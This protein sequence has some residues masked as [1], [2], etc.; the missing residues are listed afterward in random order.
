MQVTS[1]QLMCHVILWFKFVLV[2]TQHV[3]EINKEKV[4]HTQIWKVELQS[5][6]KCR[7]QNSRINLLVYLPKK[8]EIN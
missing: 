5:K 7:L 1:G 2:Y 3:S 6:K 8:P 4:C